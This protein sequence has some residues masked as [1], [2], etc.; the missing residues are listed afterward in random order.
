MHELLAIKWTEYT[1]KVSERQLTAVQDWPQMWRI[2]AVCMYT[3]ASLW[4][5]LALICCSLWG[6]HFAKAS[7][8][9]L[10]VCSSVATVEGGGERPH[11]PCHIIVTLHITLLDFKYLWSN[12][13]S[14][15]ALQWVKFTTEPRFYLCM[16]LVYNSAQTGQWYP[17]VYTVQTVWN[18]DKAALLS[19]TTGPPVFEERAWD[20]G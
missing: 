20:R 10:Q 11:L 9:R 19:P 5:K 7:S 18:L 14:L 6:W 16:Y 2:W 3:V 1:S 4:N 17:Y 13:G 12:Y 15:F 8:P